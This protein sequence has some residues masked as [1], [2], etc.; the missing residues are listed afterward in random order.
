MQKIT[1]IKS[2][3]SKKMQQITPLRLP[4]RKKILKG[5]VWSAK[6][7]KTAVILIK[8]LIEHPKYK[9]RYWVSKK[10]K[11]Q[12]PDNTYKEGDEVTIRESRPLSKEKRWTIIGKS[13]KLKSK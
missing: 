7:E 11:A 5:V 8:R 1:G 12:N 2:K 6:M 13:K 10:Y 3:N 4:S 9:K